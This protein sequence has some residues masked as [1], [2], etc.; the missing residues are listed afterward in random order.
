MMVA[1]GGSADL[2][3]GQGWG[4]NPLAAVALELSAEAAQPAQARVG[5]SSC[6]GSP[7]L[8]AWARLALAEQ[9]SDLSQQLLEQHPGHPAALTLA[10]TMEPSASQGH[11]GALHLAQWGV[12]G[13]GT[14]QRLRAACNDTSA[15]APTQ[16]QRQVLAAG[17]AN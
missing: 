3:R 6:N 10:T 11:R 1:D 2:L 14:L 7:P 9:Q 16:Q 13:P 15:T 4:R 8:S 12:R 17:L 5:V